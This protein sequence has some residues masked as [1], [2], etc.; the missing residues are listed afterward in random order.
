[1]NSPRIDDKLR[2]DST[3]TS[4]HEFASGIQSRRHCSDMDGLISIQTHTYSYQLPQ[5]PT[6]RRRERKSDSNCNVA[7]HTKLM[8]LSNLALALT[9]RPDCLP[10]HRWLSYELESWRQW[11]LMYNTGY[12]MRTIVYN[13]F[14][15]TAWTSSTIFGSILKTEV[16]FRPKQ[17]KK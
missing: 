12:S 5:I 16:D 2:L 15:K 10:L 3:Y 11:L 13:K 7:L 8:L 14:V 9:R 1:M 17:Y 6:A 4:E